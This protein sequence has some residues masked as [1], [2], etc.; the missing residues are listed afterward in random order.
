MEIKDL[1][2]FL[3]VADAGSL[4]AASEQLYISQQGLSSAIRHLEEELGYALLA[5]SHTGVTL[6]KRGKSFYEKAKPVVAVF[7]EFRH[8]VEAEG[9]RQRIAVSCAY[10]II[11]KCPLP[12]QRL[13][14]NRESAYAVSISEHF[15]TEC[16]QQLQNG[17]CSFAIVYGPVDEKRFACHTLFPLRQCFVVSKRHPFANRGSIPVA[18]LEGHPLI[19]PHRLSRSNAVLR[20]IC[21][22]AGFAPEVVLECDRPLEVVSIV[23][24][25]PEVA[26]RMFERDLQAINDPDVVALYFSDCD[27]RADVCLIEKPRQI[28]TAAERKLRRAILDCVGVSG[29]EE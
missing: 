11:P 15:F 1:Q 13:L 27:Y 19:I 17:E 21:E 10:N 24:K 5:R 14:L 3:A 16:E 23:K 8:S 18:E 22:N 29:E 9:E 6:T 4:S 28:L 26:G 12:M 20:K 2:F 7:D 25:N